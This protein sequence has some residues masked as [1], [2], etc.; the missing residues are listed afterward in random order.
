MHR[1]RP[2]VTDAQSVSR[3]R[4][5]LCGSLGAARRWSGSLV[6]LEPS[7]GSGAGGEWPFAFQWASPGGRRAGEGRLMAEM[8]YLQAISDGLREEMRRDEAVFCLGEDI[9]AFGGAV[10][11]TRGFL[12]GLGGGGG[13]GTAPGG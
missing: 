8:T 10:K 2:G 12:R 1:P 4:G 3:H 5:R 6:A 7:G 11:G 9:R 13:P